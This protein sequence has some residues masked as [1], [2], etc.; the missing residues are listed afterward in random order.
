MDDCRLV[1]DDELGRLAATINDRP[2]H[3]LLRR[4]V[5]TVRDARHAQDLAEW[6]CARYAAVLASAPACQ[7]NE[8]CRERWR[9]APGGRL[10]DLPVLDE[11]RAGCRRPYQPGDRVVKGWTGRLEAGELGRVE[12]TAETVFARHNGDN[13]PH[14]H[15]C[16]SM[17]VGDVV[18]FGEAALSVAAG[19]FVGVRLERPT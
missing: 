15:L 12:A 8:E 17:S 7:V 10:G 1:D 5:A 6:R 2:P 9:V 11:T 4:L 13:R 14:A 3:D 16:P 19:G 18:V